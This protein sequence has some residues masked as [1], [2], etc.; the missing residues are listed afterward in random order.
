MQ[1]VIATSANLQGTEDGSVSS[2]SVVLGHDL[3]VVFANVPYV[4][5]STLVHFFIALRYLTLP[6]VLHFTPYLFLTQRDELCSASLY[7]L[8]SCSSTLVCLLLVFISLLFSRYVRSLR[9]FFFV[10]G[11]CCEV[12]FVSS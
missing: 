6:S 4:G 10:F 1:G 7:P 9:F 3:R 5:Y 2:A 8:L 11:P 12:P